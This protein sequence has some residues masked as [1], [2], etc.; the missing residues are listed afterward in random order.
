MI[1]V[2]VVVAIPQGLWNDELHQDIKDIL[3]KNITTYCDSGVLSEDIIL[4]WRIFP[5]RED[6]LEKDDNRRIES[7]ITDKC[8]PWENRVLQN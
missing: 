6:K 7:L 8:T 4:S 1:I 5:H 3:M 2:F